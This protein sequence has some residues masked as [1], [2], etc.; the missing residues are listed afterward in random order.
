MICYLNDCYIK[1]TLPTFNGPCQLVIIGLLSWSAAR[2]GF[3]YRHEPG[4]QF[5]GY[6][7][8]VELLGSTQDTDFDIRP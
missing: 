3:K 6:P 1:H 4:I 2:I 5:A 7:A 8:N